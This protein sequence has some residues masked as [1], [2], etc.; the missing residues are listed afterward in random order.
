MEARCVGRGRASAGCLASWAIPIGRAFT[1]LIYVQWPISVGPWT[2]EQLHHSALSLTIGSCGNSILIC[3]FIHSRFLFIYFI[4]F[5]PDLSR[6][7][8]LCPRPLPFL[9]SLALVPS[10]DTT[11]TISI[12]TLA[13][14]PSLAASFPPHIHRLL[15]SARNCC[16]SALSVEES[17]IQGP[18]PI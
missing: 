9:S 6:C 8:R 4:L 18:S 14:S 7:G 1:G 2:E 10:T 16:S 17:Q 11:A 12:L 5:F 3:R 13:H 15:S